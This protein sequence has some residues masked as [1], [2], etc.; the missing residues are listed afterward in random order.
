MRQVADYL[1]EAYR[2][3]ILLRG[4]LYLQKI[5]DNRVRG[6]RRAN[7][8]MFQQLRGPQFQQ[9]VI[10]LTPMWDKMTQEEGSNYESELQTNFLGSLIQNGSQV[11]RFTRERPRLAATEILYRLIQGHDN[12]SVQI[13][14]ELHRGMKLNQTG[15]G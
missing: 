15:A 3:N 14:R 2:R 12:A 8:R 4:I 5:D 1:K 13:Q 6:S 11:M 7:L 9:R 10:I